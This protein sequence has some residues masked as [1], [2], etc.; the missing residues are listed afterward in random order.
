MACIQQD[1]AHY[2]PDTYKDIYLLNLLLYWNAVEFATYGTMY[3]TIPSTGYM[4][5]CIAIL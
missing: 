2:N 3:W 1:C 4:F 5:G